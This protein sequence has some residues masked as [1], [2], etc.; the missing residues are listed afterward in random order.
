MTLRQKLCNMALKCMWIK[1]YLY[2][3]AIFV[4][5]LRKLTRHLA[6]IFGLKPKCQRHDSDAVKSVIRNFF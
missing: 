6:V 5:R 3:F 2:T 1:M 4:V